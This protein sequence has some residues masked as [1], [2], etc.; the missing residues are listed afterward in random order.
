M[1]RGNNRDSSQKRT[2]VWGN[3]QAE[4]QENILYEDPY[5]DT[6]EEEDIVDP[7]EEEEIEKREL[8]GIDEEREV[9]DVC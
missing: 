3:G 4:D 9:H 2:N 1:K 8:E 5:I 6:Y 7:K